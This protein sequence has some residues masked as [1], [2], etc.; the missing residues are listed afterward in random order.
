MPSIKRRV[1]GDTARVA[2]RLESIVKRLSRTSGH[3]RGF[4]IPANASVDIERPAID[5]AAIKTEKPV[6]ITV[7]M[8]YQTFHTHQLR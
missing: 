6:S 1:D 3:R 5:L 7:R 8:T 2:A 4:D